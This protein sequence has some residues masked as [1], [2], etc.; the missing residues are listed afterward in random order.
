MPTISITSNDGKLNAASA[1]LEVSAT[2]PEYN[3]PVLRIKQ[4]GERGGA[5]SLRI[6]DPNPDIEFVETGLTGPDP[7]AGKYEIAVQ[8]DRFQINGRK[9]DNTGFETIVVFQRLAAGGNIGIGFPEDSLIKNFG[10]GQGVIA[11]AN[12]SV[13]PSADLAG[14]GILYVEDGALK[15]RGSNGTVTVLAPA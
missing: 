12:A 1:V 4:A 6:D 5:A 8:A 15:Y 2:N 9:A 14:G 11:I 13:A 7:G 10:G 3:Q